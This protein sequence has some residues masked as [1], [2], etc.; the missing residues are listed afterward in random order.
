MNIAPV[1]GEHWGLEELLAAHMLVGNLKS[2]NTAP[3][4]VTPQ[5]VSSTNAK[6]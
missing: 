6:V 5:S 2:V 4:T 1:R 3:I